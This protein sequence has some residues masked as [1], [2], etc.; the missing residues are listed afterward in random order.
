MVDTKQLKPLTFSDVLLDWTLRLLDIIRT[1]A[2]FNFSLFS[3]DWSCSKF[4]WVFFIRWN[5]KNVI[6]LHK[7]DIH[8]DIYLDFHTI[9]ILT[10]LNPHFR[11]EGEKIGLR[12]WRY[13]SI[14]TW[15]NNC[16]STR[17]AAVLEYN[18]CS[19]GFQALS[20]KSFF[21]VREIE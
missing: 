8:L 19:I 15:L 17:I 7:L 16:F 11:V 13:H 5:M 20:L 1:L 18:S 4:L 21:F 6:C 3:F 2:F 10:A 9:F 14:G 12:N